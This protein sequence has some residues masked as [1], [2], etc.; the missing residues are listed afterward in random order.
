VAEGG[1]WEA[2]KGCV[3][4]I[5]IGGGEGGGEKTADKVRFAFKVFVLRAKILAKSKDCAVAG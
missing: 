4:F 2:G 1:R 3:S 5:K